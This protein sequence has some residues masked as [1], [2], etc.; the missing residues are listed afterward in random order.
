MVTKNNAASLSAANMNA[1]T[2]SN[3]AR[4]AGATLVENDVVEKTGLMVNF[5]STPKSLRIQL[6]ACV[7][8]AITVEMM[9]V[10]ITNVLSPVVESNT[11]TAK[12]TMVGVSTSKPTGTQSK[13]VGSKTKQGEV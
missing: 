6:E 3:S 4:T 9:E 11:S 8:T 1:K 13:T 10:S 2:I 7:S 12:A 5:V